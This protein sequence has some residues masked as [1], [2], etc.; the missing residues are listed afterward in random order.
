MHRDGFSHHEDNVHYDDE[1][2]EPFKMRLNQFGDL[3]G[4]AFKLYAPDHTGSRMK[5]CSVQ[6]VV[7][8]EDTPDVD[9]P[10]SVDWTNVNGKNQCQCGSRWAFSNTGSIE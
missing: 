7:M 9:A 1:D 6:R 2:E 10:I 8:R 5:H 3:T 4:G